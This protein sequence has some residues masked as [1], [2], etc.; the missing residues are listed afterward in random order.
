ME[1]WPVEIKI[2]M[3]SIVTMLVVLFSNS[4]SSMISIL[5]SG[6]LSFAAGCGILTYIIRYVEKRE[7]LFLVLG[8]L[9]LSFGVINTLF[10]IY[11]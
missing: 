3:Y 11:S 10:Y 5:I 1:S 9:L 8:L 6:I 2:S 7:T 4:M